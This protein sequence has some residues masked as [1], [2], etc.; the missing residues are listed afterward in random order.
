MLV[1]RRSTSVF[2][3]AVSGSSGKAYRPAIIS[4]QV[5]G[6]LGA[7]NAH[8]G[9]YL[10]R[11]FRDPLLFF[12]GDARGVFL[13]R[14][15]YL[16]ARRGSGAGKLQNRADRSRFQSGRQLVR[17]PNQNLEPDFLLPGLQCSDDLDRR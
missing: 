10:L 17:S 9:A 2:W 7:G 15:V 3:S 11:G 14:G 1:I 5:H 6:I 4:I 16:E 8:G 12:L 13:V